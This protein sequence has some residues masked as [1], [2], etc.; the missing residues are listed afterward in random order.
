MCAAVSLVIGDFRPCALVCDVRGDAIAA[1]PFQ[2]KNQSRW[3]VLVAE[4]KILTENS[5]L[6]ASETGESPQVCETLNSMSH[7][8]SISR[9]TVSHVGM[10]GEASSVNS[11]VATI[12]NWFHAF[13]AEV[14]RQISTLVIAF[15]MCRCTIC[16]SPSRH[17]CISRVC[18][19][20]WLVVGILIPQ[21][22]IAAHPIQIA[23]RVFW[24]AE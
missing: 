21:R 9:F 17:S 12:R 3:H 24:K 8:R 10:R 14:H 6:K 13:S 23:L 11:P 2:T 1:V 5:T 16:M 19:T 7:C 15:L 22:Q 20:I 18:A 4:E